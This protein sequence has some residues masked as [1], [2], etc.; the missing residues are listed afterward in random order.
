MS[1]IIQSHQTSGR[2]VV[3]IDLDAKPTLAR[4]TG[5]PEGGIKGL[6]SR[7]RRESARGALDELERRRIEAEQIVAKA[8][9]E[10][11]RIQQEAYHEGFAQGEAA[12]A[13]LAEQKTEAAINSIATLVEA[14]PRERELFVERHG[15]D[16]IRIAIS[17]AVRILHRE[18][19]ADGEA[20]LRV[21][22]AALNDVAGGQHV[23]LKVSPFDLEMLQRHMGE[24]DVKPGWLTGGVRLEGDFEIGRGGCMIVT[25]SGEIDATIE[26][27]IRVLKTILASE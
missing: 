6:A 19:E 26:G 2:R 15:P 25:D 12:G 8:K 22:K 10:A 3:D 27:Q 24:G 1:S 11:D 16:L 21:A 4:Q 17:I 20:V 7:P 13:K 23:L 14:V 18:I 5:L 9:S